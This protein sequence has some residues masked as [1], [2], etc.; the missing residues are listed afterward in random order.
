MLY[1]FQLQGGVC[2]FCPCGT[3]PCEVEKDIRITVWQQ[4]RQRLDLLLRADEGLG[5]GCIRF[6]P[7]AAFFL[8]QDSD[9]LDTSGRQFL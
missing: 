4:V 2:T 8:P 3:F 7:F 6:Y 1:I 9:C 5:A